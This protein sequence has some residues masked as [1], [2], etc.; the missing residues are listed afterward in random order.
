MSECTRKKSDMT[1]CFLDDPSL[2]LADDGVCVGCGFDPRQNI[3]ELEALCA[4]VADER[5]TAFMMS[6][7]ECGP[8]EACRELAKLRKRAEA[9]EAKLERYLA[10]AD[11]MDESSHQS[12]ARGRYWAE[13]LREIGEGDDE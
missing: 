11:E 8:K 4:Q 10:L 1:P 3:R 6:K 13:R 2:A 12:S 9:A 5:D 7:C